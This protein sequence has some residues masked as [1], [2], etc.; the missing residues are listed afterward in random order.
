MDSKKK[1]KKEKEKKERKK[2]KSKAACLNLFLNLHTDCQQRVERL[3]SLRCLK[4]IFNPV[5]NSKLF[6]GNTHRKANLKIKIK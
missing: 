4:I 3:I 1:Q 2:D 6:L 5:L